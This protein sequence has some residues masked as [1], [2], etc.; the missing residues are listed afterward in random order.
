MRAEQIL[1][2]LMDDKKYKDRVDE[3]RVLEQKLSA[4]QAI[5]D[6]LASAEALKKKVEEKLVQTAQLEMVLNAKFAAKTAELQEEFKRQTA[7]LNARV[8]QERVHFQG[9]RQLREEARKWND[10][11][12]KTK[13]DVE[14]REKQV[15][16][17]LA[18]LT[19]R[20]KILVVKIKR[21]QDAWSD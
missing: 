12:Q 3:L 20:E 8:A 10:E 7:E 14:Q 1:E 9:S 11:V 15:A 16:E 19:Q 5:T 2:V 17:Q 13:V 6:T 21:L 18:A 4:A